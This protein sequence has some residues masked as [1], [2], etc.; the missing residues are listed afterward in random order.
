VLLQ[1]LSHPSA[2]SFGATKQHATWMAPLRPGPGGGGGQ[3]WLLASKIRAAPAF[4]CCRA[5]WRAVVGWLAPP[6][7]VLAAPLFYSRDL[8][9]K[10]GGIFFGWELVRAGDRAPSRRVAPSRVA[11]MRRG[12]VARVHVTYTGGEGDRTGIVYHHPHP[13][14]TFDIIHSHHW[15]LQKYHRGHLQSHMGVSHCTWIR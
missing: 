13:F 10:P 3:R 5:L 11:W 1:C 14:E 4:G 12:H 8:E 7:M 2:A 15:I 9:E 6:R